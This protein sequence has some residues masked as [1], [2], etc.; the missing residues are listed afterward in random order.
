MEMIASISSRYAK[1]QATI[2]DFR[3]IHEHSST[4]IYV[5]TRSHIYFN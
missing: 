4:F 5:S 1:Y 2:E 3:I